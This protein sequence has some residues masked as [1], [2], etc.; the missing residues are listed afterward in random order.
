MTNIVPEKIET[1]RLTLRQFRE[2]DWQD[3]HRYYSDESAMK[4]TVGRT[5]TEGET[6]R[7]LCSMLGHWAIRKYGPYAVEEKSSSKVIGIVGFWYPNDWPSPE[8]KWAL[9]PKYWGKGFAKEA[10]KAVQRVGREYMPNIHLISLIHSK[11]HAS[12]KLAIALGSTLES[13]VE[14]RNA[15]FEIYRHPK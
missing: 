4:Y 6:W 2:D 13:E 9:S 5:F 15:I 11:N 12:K 14:F 3:L 7:A 8:I 1:E 10:A